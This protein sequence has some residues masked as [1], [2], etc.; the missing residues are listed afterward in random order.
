MFEFW[1][2]RYR[3]SLAPL[4]S[5]SHYIAMK[6]HNNTERHGWPTIGMWSKYKTSTI[7]HIQR[8]RFRE[9]GH[10]KCQRTNNCLEPLADD[11]AVSKTSITILNG[12]DRRL[13]LN[14]AMKIQN[15]L[16]RLVISKWGSGTI[17]WAI[18]ELRGGRFGNDV[19]LIFTAPWQWLL[20]DISKFNLF[21]AS[22]GYMVK[23]L[24]KKFSR[25]SVKLRYYCC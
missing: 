20:D 7:W 24:E 19:V 13:N 10:S 21:P 2:W 9:D 15:Y 16:F 11:L 14:F 1:I 17:I 6:L 25:S 4:P 3:R 12:Y 23:F 22:L 18:N 8:L 5:F